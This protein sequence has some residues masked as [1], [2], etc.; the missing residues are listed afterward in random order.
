MFATAVA[1]DAH[2]AQAI[3]RMVAAHPVTSMLLAMFAVAYGLLIP[4]ALSGL[5]VEPFLLGA[6]LL[7]QLLPS[8]LVT[9][10]VGGRPA[11]RQLFGRIFRWRVDLRWYL[12]ALLVIP[13]ASLSA[14]AVIF[15]PGAL[16]AL[17]T[18]PSVVASYLASLTI[19]PVVNLWEETAWTGVIQARLIERRGLLLAAVLTGPPF[20]LLHLPLELSRPVGDVLGTMALLMLAVIPF[21]LVIGWLY[22]RT[23]ASVLLVAVLHATFNATNN[24]NL[25]TAARPD[26]ADLLSVTPWAVVVLWAALLLLLGA[27]HRR[28]TRP[29][30]RV[31]P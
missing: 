21:R 27:P 17:V 10:A 11:I 22:Q 23:G 16:Q 26:R 13:V 19:L 2:P 25:L 29:P 20:A 18:D 7:G 3:R 1:P 12:V 15:G 28:S 4:A 24:T 5:P 31:L 6:V 14:S 9:A 30:P 8:V